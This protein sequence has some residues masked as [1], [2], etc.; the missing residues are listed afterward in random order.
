MAYAALGEGS[1]QQ[2][3]GEGSE[4]APGAGTAGAWGMQ[5]PPVGLHKLW[6][7]IWIKSIHLYF[8]YSCLLPDLSFSLSG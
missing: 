3:Q 7:L 8:P 2:P 6:G 5:H 1:G 4:A